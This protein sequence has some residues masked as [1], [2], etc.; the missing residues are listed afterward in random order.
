MTAPDER[1]FGDLRSLLGRE[2]AAIALISFAAFLGNGILFPVLPL[3]LDHLGASGATVGMA[4]A[5]LGLG[6]G[7][8]GFF[9]GALTDRRGVFIPLAVFM[10][11]SIVSYAALAV[12][13][14]IA[15][16]LGLRF[17]LAGLGAAIWPAGRGYFL[18]AVP[19]R[20]K[21]RAVAAFGILVAGGLS[22][23]GFT[24]GIIV[25][26]FGYDR[27]F[28]ILAA[29]TAV[30]A[31]V[32]LPRLWGAAVARPAAAPGVSGIAP[33]VQ[34]F[35]SIVTGPVLTVGAI[36]MLVAGSY[37]TVVSFVPLLVARSGGSASG[38]GVI[39]GVSTA[40]SLLILPY[41]G[42]LA[43]RAGRRAVMMVTLV[44][45]AIAILSLG[46][47]RGYWPVLGATGLM[48]VSRWAS[49]PAMVA[50]LSD[51]VP[52][53]AQGRAQGVHVIAFDLGLLTGPT[54]AGV[55]WDRSGAAAT[56]GFA[57]LLAAAAFAVAWRRV[58]ERV[59]GLG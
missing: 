24:S 17:V 53:G 13:P 46:F 35:R 18:Q 11:G 34:S 59:W 55:I 39:F 41:A 28:W 20:S 9:W 56:F 57:A 40:A 12:L 4:L 49:D 27:L 8:F 1:G 54:A 45:Y 37:G 42:H 19:A 25:D 3:Y 48:F 47:A 6:E 7:L 26:A 22:V 23:G 14:V 32:T 29:V 10:A 21:G 38:V 2:G 51:V 30:T 15:A 36:V 44:V 58:R 43:D 33:S 50:L 5:L 52:R 31:G 16:V